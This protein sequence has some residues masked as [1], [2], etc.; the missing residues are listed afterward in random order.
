M[1]RF[2]QMLLTFGEGM[3]TTGGFFVS[4]KVTFQLG[5]SSLTLPQ[6]GPKI[7]PQTSSGLSANLSK[8]LRTSFLNSGMI[9]VQTRVSSIFNFIHKNLASFAMNSSVL[10]NKNSF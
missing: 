5:Y 1:Q 4:G 6:E 10:F 2:E 3:D 9:P 8:T 7:T